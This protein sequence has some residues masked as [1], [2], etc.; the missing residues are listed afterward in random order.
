MKRLAFI[1][2]L[3]SV[4]LVASYTFASVDEAAISKN[5]DMIVAGI[6]GGQDIQEIKADAYQPYAF[7]MEPDGKML[8][9][10]SLMGESLAEKAPPVYEALMQATPEGVWVEYEWQGKVKHTYAKKTK[11]NLIVGSGY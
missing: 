3:F 10:P 7:V 9:H 2:S 5:V 8:V 6:E 11:D 4:L 1:V